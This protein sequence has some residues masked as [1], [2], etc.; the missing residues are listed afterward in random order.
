MAYAVL[1]GFALFFMG[2][3]IAFF[4]SL[5]RAPA[6][7]DATC[8]K[9]ISELRAELALPD[10]ALADHLD[11]LL[12]QISENATKVL[13]FVLLHEQID[14]PHIKIEGLPFADIQ[15]ARYECVT[16][17]LLRINTVGGGDDPFSIRVMLGAHEFYYVPPE[18]RQVLQRLLYTSAR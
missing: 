12:T 18:F 16:A 2:W 6:Q 4:V 5:S 10:E 13:R 3:G 11:G 8:R 14:T 9:E 7:L 15:K 17:G 1:L